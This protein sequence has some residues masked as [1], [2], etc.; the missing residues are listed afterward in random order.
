MKWGEVRTLYPEQWV[1][2]RIV[3]SH[4]ENDYLYID[5]V[6]VIQAISNDKDATHELVNCKDNYIVFHT[7]HD[8]IR[9]KIINNM[10]I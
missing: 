8:T 7:S 3:K 5:E 6:D 1:K 4:K 2:L 10:G 9:T